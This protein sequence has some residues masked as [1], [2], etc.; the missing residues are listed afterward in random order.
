VTVSVLLLG[1]RSFIGR[2]CLE[3]WC[4]H[5]FDDLSVTALSSKDLDLVDRSAVDD[6]FLNKHF[7]YVILSA[8]NIADVEASLAMFFNVVRNASSYQTFINLGSGAEYDPVRYAPRMAEHYSDD[9]FPCKGYPLIKAVQGKFIQ[10]AEHFCGINLRIFGVFGKYEDTSRRFITN[11]IL[12]GL[13][14]GII[15]C[16]QDMLFDYLHVNTL[17]DFLARIMR[18]RVQFEHRSYNFC[19]GK[20][21][22]LVE[23]GHIIRDQIPGSTFTVKNEGFGGEYSGDPT[24]LE[25]EF[26]TIHH[27]DIRSDISELINF[28][29]KTAAF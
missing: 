6:F 12:A 21:I 16:R 27:N 23:L 14:S 26:G 15:S 10:S 9:A 8:V 4:E 13:R 3:Y 28:F 20:P 24:R 11:N 25:L 2:S 19:T 1:S 22:S 17:A 7:D 29:Q 5:G 18:D